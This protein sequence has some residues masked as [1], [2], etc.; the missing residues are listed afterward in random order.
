MQSRK[1]SEGIVLVRNLLWKLKIVTRQQVVGVT[2]VMSHY[3]YALQHNATHCNT[4]QHTAT[5]C[6]TSRGGD[7]SHVTLSK[8]TATQCN[9]LQ[10]NATHCN[11]WQHTATHCNTSRGGNS[12]HVTLSKCTATQCNIM[13][14]TATQCN[15][16]QQKSWRWR[17]P[18]S[19]LRHIIHMHM[20]C[21]V[22]QCF[23]LCCIV[24]QCV[25]VCCSVLQCIA[26]YCSAWERP[27]SH[28]SYPHESRCSYELCRSAS[29]LFVVSE[30]DSEGVPRNS[31]VTQVW[32]MY[33]YAHE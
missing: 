30:Y 21:S 25:A 28:Y 33:L 12:S 2:H 13:Q 24:L 8:C 11:T 23:A 4:W 9:T 22:L 3:S 7:S 15:T 19:D 29:Y 6:N 31:T 14:H 18:A 26:V 16:L 1:F 17:T 27:T 20:Y 5:H 32:R 10:H